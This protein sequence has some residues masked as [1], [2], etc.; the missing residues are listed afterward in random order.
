MS[1]Y[2]NIKGAEDPKT[3]LANIKA[4]GY[5]TSLNYVQNLMSAIEK[6]NLRQYDKRR[7]LK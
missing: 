5:A 4:D 6:Y 1:N 2:I 7:S 3:Y